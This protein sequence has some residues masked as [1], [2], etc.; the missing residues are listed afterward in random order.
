MYNFRNIRALLRGFT[1][2]GTLNKIKSSIIC[3]FVWF[4]CE[5]WAICFVSRVFFNKVSDFSLTASTY[6][7][8]TIRHAWFLS[9]QNVSQ[10]SQR[11]QNN[12][13]NSFKTTFSDKHCRLSYTKLYCMYTSANLQILPIDDKCKIVYNAAFM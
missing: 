2:A 10:F 9:G 3:C 13:F 6:R 4:W 8:Y 5:M 12:Q 7:V 11:F 1:S